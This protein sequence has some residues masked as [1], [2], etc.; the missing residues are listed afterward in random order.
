MV[1]VVLAVAVAI[2]VVVGR[3]D[4]PGNRRL[5]VAGSL[6]PLNAQTEAFLLASL[7]FSFSSCGADNQRTAS[8]QL[9][10]PVPDSIGQA[11]LEEG[12]V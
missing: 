3:N 10:R 2:V 7:Q 6:D 9:Q 5:V 12:V 1:A 11:G 8:G 4:H